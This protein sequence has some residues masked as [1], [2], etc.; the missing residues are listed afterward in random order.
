M[1][2]SPLKYSLSSHI[3]DKKEATEYRCIYNRT[4]K[5]KKNDHR[6]IEASSNSKSLRFNF[7][8]NL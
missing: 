4:I 3:Q 2:P 6:N 7:W 5:G 8:T 1:V